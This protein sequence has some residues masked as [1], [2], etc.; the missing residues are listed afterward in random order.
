MLQLSNGV[1]IIFEKDYFQF[2]I[3]NSLKSSKPTGL[4]ILVDLNGPQKPNSVGEDIFS[5]TVMADSAH[6]LE[7]TCEYTIDYDG[8]NTD[9]QKVN[10]LD[11]G[12]YKYKVYSI[13]TL[14]SL[15][16]SDNQHAYCCA[17]YIKASGWKIPKDY[18]WI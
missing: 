17:A 16:E 6:K 4:R 15:C 10:Y 9:A 13:E 14:K 12:K 11:G 18:P 2:K 7:A 3:G 5:Y 8:Y 1:T